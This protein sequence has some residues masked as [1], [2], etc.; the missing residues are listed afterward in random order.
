VGSGDVV[1]DARPAAAD[2]IRLELLA[3]NT[4]PRRRNTRFL[5]FAQAGGTVV[6]KLVGEVVTDPTGPYGEALVL[7]LGPPDEQ[8]FAVREINLRTL[9]RS[10]QTRVGGRTARRYLLEAPRRCR[11]SWRTADS[12]EYANGESLLAADASPCDPR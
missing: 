10:V 2:P 8:Q 6:S 9:N 3:Y 4:R 11:G 7:D 12:V 5:F 1:V